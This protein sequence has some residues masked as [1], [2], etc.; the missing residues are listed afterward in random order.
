MVRYN[1]DRTANPAYCTSRKK[2]WLYGK[3]NSN[4]RYKAYPLGHLVVL[5]FLSQS[6]TVSCIIRILFTVTPHIVHAFSL[7]LPLCLP[8]LKSLFM[9]T[10]RG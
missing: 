5:L 8:S 10:E 2:E 1:I 9:L 3:W 7:F 6:G 4:V